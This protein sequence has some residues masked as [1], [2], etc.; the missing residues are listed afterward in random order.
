MLLLLIA[1]LLFFSAVVFSASRA[2]CTNSD[3]LQR[4]LHRVLPCAESVLTKMPIRYTFAGR[5]HTADYT[6]YHYSFTSLTWP[7]RNERIDP[8]T[9]TTWTHELII[10]Q[11]KHLDKNNKDTAVL[12]IDGGSNHTTKKNVRYSNEVDPLIAELIKHTIVVRIRYVPNEYLTISGK[13]MREDEIVSYTWN[14]F[15][16]NPELFYYPLHVPMTVAAR[17]AMTL[18]QNLLEKREIHIHHFIVM[19][20]SKRGLGDLDDS[21]F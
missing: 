20:L 7:P 13:P 21:T 19:G 10:Y 6:A 14:R 12:S 11:P 1:S 16:H 9:P 8:I 5:S 17:Q 18:A 2:D 15:I 4:D 3:F